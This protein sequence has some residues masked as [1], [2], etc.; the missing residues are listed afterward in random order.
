MN[1]DPSAAIMRA[2]M[3]TRPGAAAGGQQMAA[4]APAKGFQGAEG[5]M[6]QGGDGGQPTVMGRPDN[7]AAGA[8]A[9]G[10]QPM[11]GGQQPPPSYMQTQGYS[12][13]QAQSAPPADMYARLAQNIQMAQ[14]AYRAYQPTD[15]RA[16]P[17]QQYQFDPATDPSRI[18]LAK[19]AERAA[20]DKADAEAKA[21]ATEPP[22][23]DPYFLGGGHDSP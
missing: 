3:V 19:L 17:R 21:Q 2:L 5:G 8:P 1:F 18:V 15:F 4:G 10:F 14:P 7:E 11:E 20:K 12:Q 16:A 23:Y 9:K 22:P 13:P 6:P